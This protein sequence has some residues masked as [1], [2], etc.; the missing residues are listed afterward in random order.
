MKQLK[1]LWV[2]DD[3]NTLMGLV[4]PLL[5]DGHEIVIAT[6]GKEALELI[7]KDNY[8]L[9]LFDLIIPTGIKNDLGNNH[10]VGV[11]LLNNIL[12]DMGIN[13]PTIVLSV[14]H[15]PDIYKE[16]NLMGVNKILPKSA[17]LPTKLKNDIYETLGLKNE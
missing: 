1:I 5:K 17:Y 2:E 4:R 9:L 3:A 15:D 6:D 14:V 13:T 12:K 16:L 10:F 8:D 7:K 11:S